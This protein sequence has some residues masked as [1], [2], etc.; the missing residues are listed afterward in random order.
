VRIFK[1]VFPLALVAAMVGTVVAASAPTIVMPGKEQWV[2]QQGGYSMAVLYGDP[3]KSGFYVV[4]LK[5]GSNWTFPPHYHPGRENV[6]VISGTFYAGIGKK[7]DAKKMTAFPAGSFISLPPGT[8]HYAMT[9]QPAVIE[10][11][12]TE[13]MKNVMLK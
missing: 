5:T 6:T 2:A 4:R 3:S 8:P 12:G 9:K 11:T 13:P 10:L 1:I 7:M